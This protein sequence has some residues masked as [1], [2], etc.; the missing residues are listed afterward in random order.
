VNPSFSPWILLGFFAIFLASCAMF[1]IHVLRWT[2][3]KR[4][5]DLRDWGNRNGF[6]LHK[7]R[8][9]ALPLPLVHLTLPPPRVHWSLRRKAITL[10]EI[11]TPAPVSAPSKL[12]PRWNLLVREMEVDWPVT[13]LRPM[14]HE[15]S[16]VDL[17]NLASFPA[18][19]SSERFTVH[20][21]DAP[22]A[23]AMAKSM[24][25]ALLPRDLAILLVGR[26]I[27]ID[28]SKRPFDGIELSRMAALADQLLSHLPTLASKAA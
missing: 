15:T 27:I 3:R 23:R 17:F 25:P 24:L 28:F 10:L 19:L 1:R 26:Y 21:V 9:A 18:L 14:L 2:V 4:W 16:L 12:A 6:R 11:D 22:T 5:L 20:G 13:A 8:D 7:G